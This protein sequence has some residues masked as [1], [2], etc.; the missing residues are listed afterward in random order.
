MKI[1][2]NVFLYYLCMLIFI[3]PRCMY[4][5][6]GMV[7]FT[8]GLAAVRYILSFIAVLVFFAFRKTRIYVTH[9]YIFSF[10]VAVLL[11]II[12]LRANHSIYLTA[13]LSCFT[14]VGFILGNIVLYQKNE[15]QLLVSY[16]NYLGACLLIH[17][18]TIFILPDTLFLNG[19]DGQQVYFMGQKNG[20]APYALFFFLTEYLICNRK[21]FNS[22]EIFRRTGILAAIMTIFSVVNKS[23]ALVGAMMM[24]DGYFCVTYLIKFHKKTKGFFQRIYMIIA[25]VLVFGFL[26]MVVILQNGSDFIM[27]VITSV[28]GKDATFSGRRAIWAQAIVFIIQNPL[29]GLGINVQYDVWGNNKFVYSAHN[30]FL[31]Y[32]VKYGCISLFFIVLGIA[33]IFVRGIKARNDEKLRLCTI[34]CAALVLVSLFEALEGNYLTWATLLFTYLA[35]EQLK[36]ELSSEKIIIKSK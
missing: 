4:N 16:R 1:R 24:I 12:S 32:G 11:Q 10:V 33:V 27:R 36:Q 15:V 31:D 23:S 22:K 34:V 6:K 3:P 21:T 17:V 35:S 30:M 19:P 2:R 13:A 9:T 14:F 25:V 8:S 5:M 18:A 29:W 20:V 28:V 7:L 26:Y